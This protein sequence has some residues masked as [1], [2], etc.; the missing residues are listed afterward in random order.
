MKPVK[1][2]TICLL[3]GDYLEAEFEDDIVEAEEKL[4]ELLRQADAYGIDIDL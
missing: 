3:V 4:E 1:A 2:T